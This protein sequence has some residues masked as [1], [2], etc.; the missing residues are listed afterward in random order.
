[1]VHRFRPKRFFNVLGGHGPVLR[2]APG[3]TLITSTLDAH[4]FNRNDEQEALSPNPV[5]GPF[6]IE[7]AKPGD[8]LIVEIPRITLTR[9]TGWSSTILAENMVEPSYLNAFPEKEY[10]KWSI[11]AL[12]DTTAIIEP[13]ECRGKITLPLAPLIGC[14]GVSP[15]DGQVISTRTSAEHGGNMD[16]RGVAQ[17]AMLYFPVFENGALFNVG[18]I[19]AAQGD[20]EAAG[21]GIETSAEVELRFSVRKKYSIRWP[22]GENKTHIFTIGNAR[23]LE[24]AVQ[25]ATTEMHR[26]LC[27]EYNHNTVSASLL[28]G[29]SAQYVIG[30]VFNPAYTV[31]CKILK[32]HLSG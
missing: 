24:Q 5:T 4:G 13:E 17:G 14:M 9:E 31:S 28:M 19:H 1:V 32:K 23:P 26:W 8:A 10:A 3:D 18:D 7:G 30:N 27:D 15:A 2:I 25:H 29:Q 16:Y 20:G 11:D 12:K 21:T 22:R 6:Y